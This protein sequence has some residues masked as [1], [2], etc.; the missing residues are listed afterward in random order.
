MKIYNVSKTEILENP[1]LTKGYLKE[2]VL[3]IVEPEI[4]AVDEEGY[5][6]TIQESEDGKDVEWVVTKPGIPYSPEKTYIE[7]IYVYIPYTKDELKLKDYELQLR[8]TLGNLLKTDYIANK[9]AEANSKYIITN[10]KTEIANLRVLYEQEL[11]ARENW[12]LEADKL[13]SDI[14]NLKTKLNID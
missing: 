7:N 6:R 3:Q 11:I 4:K 8:E 2:D 13:K 10:D 9:L 14:S 12:R 1:D 5:Y